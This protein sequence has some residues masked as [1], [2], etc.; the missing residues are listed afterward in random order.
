MMEGVLGGHGLVPWVLFNALILGL[1]ALDL[2]VFN[3]ASRVMGIRES[4][5]WNLVWTAAGLAFAL[6][7]W[8]LYGKQSAF[9]YVTG[10]VLER[11]LSIDN[12]FVFVI[13]FRY[14][15]VP[16]EHEHRILYWGILGA[17]IMRGTLILAGAAAVARFHWVL[18]IFGVFLVYTGIHLAF[19][20]PAPPEPDKNIAVRLA[21]KI[22][23]VTRTLHGQRFFVR[24]DGRLNATPLFLVLLVV[25]TT[26]LLFA[27]D[28]IP[29]VFGITHDPFIIYT[30]NVFAILGLRA[31]YFL[32][33]AILPSFRFLNYGLSAV[34]VFIGLRMLAE[35]WVDIPIGLALTAVCGILLVAVGASLIP[36]RKTGRGS[37]PQ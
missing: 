3:R 19:K 29:A 2:G 31:M 5:V 17:L 10:Y 1:V 8:R 36:A 26:D 21:S 15:A 9:E 20:D 27:F 12:I 32:L 11:A 22:F 30:S 13:V 25:E 7:V 37:P 35:P 6:L 28:S 14:F 16:R 18:Y 33:A 23:P 4:V 24:R 34:L